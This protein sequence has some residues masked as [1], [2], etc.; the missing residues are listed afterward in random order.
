MANLSDASVQEMLSGRYIGSLATQNEDGT[1]H[2]VAVW[3]YFD[4]E[5]IYVA[6]AGYSRKAKNV[7]RSS[8][9]S[10][11]IDGRD[12]AAQRGSASPV[13]RGC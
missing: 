9:V 6:T 13:L 11:M 4:G 8:Q 1:T 2:M 12:L 7:K 10:L 5:S 3:C